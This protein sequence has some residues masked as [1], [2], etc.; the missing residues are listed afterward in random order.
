VHFQHERLIGGLAARFFATL[1]GPIKGSM[2]EIAE[3]NTF[4]SEAYERFQANDVETAIRISI[5]EYRREFVEADHCSSLTSDGASDEAKRP[6][7]TF[8]ADM[9]ASLGP[10]NEMAIS[11]IAEMK[12]V[13]EVARPFIPRV[14][15][16]Q[17]GGYPVRLNNG[18]WTWQGPHWSRRNNR[19]WKSGFSSDFTYGWGK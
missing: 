3:R 15:R 9:I 12:S 11:A 14:I 10:R 5:A 6:A 1:N 17:H 16:R 18:K 4:L 13:G 8:L 19:T 2:R 7:F